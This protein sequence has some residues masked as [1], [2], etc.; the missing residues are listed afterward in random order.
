MKKVYFLTYQ[1]GGSVFGAITE[2]HGQLPAF[3]TDEITASRF[4]ASKVENQSQYTF[5]MTDK[6]DNV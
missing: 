1:A 3:F 2:T 5:G 6:A 4:F